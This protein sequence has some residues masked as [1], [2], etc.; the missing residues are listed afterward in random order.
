MFEQGHENIDE[1]VNFSVHRS[2]HPDVPRAV[3]DLLLQQHVH[4]GERSGWHHAGHE[5]AGTY[6]AAYSITVTNRTKQLS[7]KQ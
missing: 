4:A 7:H 3:R 2:N 1:H 6:T 5:Q